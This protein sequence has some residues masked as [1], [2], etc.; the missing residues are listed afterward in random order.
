MENIFC[1]E[2]DQKELQFKMN[3]PRKT[4]LLKAACE[5]VNKSLKELNLKKTLHFVRSQETF[6]N[7]NFQNQ[8]RE[9]VN[10]TI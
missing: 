6:L 1:D 4:Q 9:V 8:V 10:L 5:D 7:N 3:N 2:D